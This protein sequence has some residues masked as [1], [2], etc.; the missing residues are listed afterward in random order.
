MDKGKSALCSSGRVPKIERKIA[1]KSRRDRMKILYTNLHCLLPNHGSKKAMSLLDQINEVVTYIESLK[2]KV[3]EM[4]EKKKYLLQRKRSH[5]CITSEIQANT[6]SSPPLVEIHDMGP[7]MDVIFVVGLDDLSKFYK[8]LH[9]LHED[10]IEVV[11]D[12]PFSEGF[13]IPKP[14]VSR[15]FPVA[16]DR[17]WLRT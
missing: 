16:E 15:S 13:R 11:T 5:S 1:E 2:M 7:N 9:L 10:S 6:K 14:P 3:E 12:R 17:L 8:I 4:K